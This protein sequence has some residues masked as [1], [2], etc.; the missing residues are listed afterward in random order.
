MEATSAMEPTQSIQAIEA[1]ELATMAA[2]TAVAHGT[3]TKA[4]VQ[5]AMWPIV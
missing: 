3:G 2:I 1:T 4:T 5:P